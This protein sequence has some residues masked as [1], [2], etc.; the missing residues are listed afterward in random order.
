LRH[1]AHQVL[2]LLRVFVISSLVL[3]LLARIVQKAIR[4]RVLTVSAAVQFYD[5]ATSIDGIDCG[6][7]SVGNV[8]F[9]EAIVGGKHRGSQ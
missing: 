4:T 7:Y 1:K 6:G 8:N 5:V 9:Y 3:Q 2:K